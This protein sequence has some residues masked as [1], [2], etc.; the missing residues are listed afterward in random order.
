[1]PVDARGINRD[2]GIQLSASFDAAPSAEPGPRQPGFWASVREAL[3]GSEQD[4]TSGPVGRSILL[5]AVPMVLEMAMESIFAITDIFFVSRLGADAVA[6]VGLTEGLLTIVYALAM[7]LSIGVTAV[8]ARRIG[9]K[10][11]EAAAASAVQGLAVALGISIVL[12]TMGVLLARPLLAAMGASPEVMEIGLGYT[13][14]MLG[15][16]ATI[17]LLFVA[18][19]IFRGAGDAA[20]AM[21]VL[22]IANGVNILL[23]PCLIF[24]LGPFPAMGVTGAAVATTIGRGTG[25]ALALWQLTRP[26]RHIRV[27]R[28]HLVPNPALMGR[29]LRLSGSATLQMIIGTAS[30]VGL[31]RIVSTFGS[32]AL[33]G[34]TIGI[35]IV[36]FALLPSMGLSNAAATMVGQALGAKKPERAEEAVWK[37]GIYNLCFLGGI[38]LLFVLFA[39]PIVSAFTTDPAVVP[40]AV[41]CLRVVAAGFLF[42]AYGMVL[43][44]SFNGA[45]D[46]WTPTVLN[47]VVFWL[48]EIPLAYVLAVPLGMGPMGVFLSITLAFSILAFAST[49]IFRRGKWK[50]RMV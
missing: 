21:R 50:T 20:I 32:A 49:M 2:I 13:R 7:G 16:E 48:F 44:Q 14:V 25:V 29:I 17:I 8:V 30:W 3:R 47:F 23:G 39:A 15:G 36:I 6:A 1:L 24:G 27:R 38:G 10:D 12:G 42:Y 4:Y 5:L 41:A 43:T 35:R 45:G 26:G 40:H 22:W 28:R 11:P 19:A 33:A 37:A 9:E 46:T 31:V 34:Y 18:N